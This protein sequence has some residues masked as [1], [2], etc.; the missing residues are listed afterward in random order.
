M[1]PWRSRPRAPPEQKKAH[2]RTMALNNTRAVNCPE[3]W[4]TSQ[5]DDATLVGRRARATTALFPTRSQPE[6]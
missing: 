4:N 6:A 3:T 2:V 5:P 1:P